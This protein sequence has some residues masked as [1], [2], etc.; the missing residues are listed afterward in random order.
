M[1]LW[2]SLD[3]NFI[4]SDVIS[5]AHANINLKHLNHLIIWKELSVFIGTN[6]RAIS[7][8]QHPIIQLIAG[9]DAPYLWKDINGIWVEKTV[10]LVAPNHA[11]ECNANGQKVVI[12][13][14]DPE[15]ILGE[16]ILYQ[17]LKN[18]S[19]IDYKSKCGRSNLAELMDLIAINDWQKMHQV[20]KSMFDFSPDISVSIKKD[21]RIQNVLDYIKKNIDTDINTHTLMEASCLSESRLLHLFKELVGLPIRNYILWCRI[22]IAFKQVI[23]GGSLTE[24]AYCAG[25]SDQAHLTRTFVTA[26][27]APPSSLLKNSKFVQVF[28]PE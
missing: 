19:I 3:S 14:I 13:S 21:E 9:V 18:D 28:F 15:S 20:I 4:T 23:E 27:G 12:I 26:I 22:Q 10:L 6:Q 17:Y 25:F 1:N 11:H 16:F 7:K 8:H 5:L 2:I 24:A